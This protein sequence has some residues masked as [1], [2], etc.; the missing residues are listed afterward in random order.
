[1]RPVKFARGIGGLKVV[2]RALHWHQLVQRPLPNGVLQLV[3]TLPLKFRA[4]DLWRVSRAA[5]SG[6][7]RLRR[8]R[9]R[10]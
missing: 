7:V 10:T 4:C 5:A 2:D 8:R 6:C 1:V 3:M 9:S